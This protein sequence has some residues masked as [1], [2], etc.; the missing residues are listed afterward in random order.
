M[1]VKLSKSQWES[2]GR[3]AGW[4]PSDDIVKEEVIHILRKK[5]ISD[6]F[7]TEVANKF[8]YEYLASEN[9]SDIDLNEYVEW[10][11]GNKLSDIVNLYKLEYPDEV[12]DMTSG[13]SESQ[14][15][16]LAWKQSR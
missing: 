2:M 10:L 5:D 14:E 12:K 16:E 7:F 3:K 1:K 13:R 8:K 6:N 11:L 4:L 9:V 15:S